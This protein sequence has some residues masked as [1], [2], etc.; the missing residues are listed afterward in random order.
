MGVGALT[1]PHHKDPSLGFPHFGYLGIYGC[2]HWKALHWPLIVGNSPLR[3]CSRTS[4]AITKK[5][6]GAPD[7]WKLPHWEHATPTRA[8]GLSMPKPKKV[9]YRYV[10]MN[11]SVYMYIYIYG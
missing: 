4:I 3:C 5:P 10:Y 8:L 11:I 9:D 2:L 1:I 6:R 7:F